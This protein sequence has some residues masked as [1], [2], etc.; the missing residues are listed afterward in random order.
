[1]LNSC[2]LPDIQNTKSNHSIYLNRVGINNLRLPMSVLQQNNNFQQTIGIFECFV[3]LD[4]NIKGISMSRL[5]EVLHE[6]T[7]KPLDNKVITDITKTLRKRCESNISSVSVLFPYFI[8]KTSPVTHKKGL[9]EY[10]CGFKCFN[11]NDKITNS[12]FVKLIVT[13]LCPCSKEISENG[14]HNQ[15]C[16]IECEFETSKWVWFEDIIKDL[17]FCGSSQIYSILKRPDEKFV[18][19]QAYNNPLFVEDIARNVYTCL[20]IKYNNH[21][22]KFKINVYSDESIHIHKAFA[23]ANKG[24]FNS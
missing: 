13:S 16:Y 24:E 22:S 7:N 9:V 12:L 11:D 3:D 10:E 2:D 8:E 23:F 20:D 6:D 17:E 15:K 1:M 21:I 18:T 19:E 14:A 4:K 5:L